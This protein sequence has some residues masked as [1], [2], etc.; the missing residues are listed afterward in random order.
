MHGQGEFRYANGDVYVGQFSRGK[1]H[2]QGRCV[3]AS[4]DEYAGA[5]AQDMMH[6]PGRFAF[7]SGA[8]YEGGFKD[9]F[10]HGRGRMPATHPSPECRPPTHHYHGGKVSRHVGVAV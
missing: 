10:F 5:Y 2:G 9:G 4:G 3:L 6:G 8:L 1:K 7:S